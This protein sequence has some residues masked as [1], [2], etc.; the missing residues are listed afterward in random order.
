MLEGSEVATPL[1]L[2]PVAQ[3]GEA[4]LHQCRGGRKISLGKRVTPEGVPVDRPPEIALRKPGCQI[5]LRP[6]HHLYF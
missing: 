3:I 6:Q 5:R 4:L 1:R 2:A